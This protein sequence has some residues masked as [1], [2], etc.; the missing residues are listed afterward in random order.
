ML[1]F[2]SYLSVD[3]IW[4]GFVNWLLSVNWSTVCFHTA[5]VLLALTILILIISFIKTHYRNQD[6]YDE[7]KQET[8]TI[9]VYRIDG[10]RNNVRFF[11]LSNIS[12]VK[13]VTMKEFFDGFP[14]RERPRVNEW[15]SEILDGKVTTQYLQTDVIFHHSNKESPSFLKISKADPTKGII[16]LESYLLRY[17]GSENEKGARHYSTES[18]FAQAVKANGVATGI[19]FC[20]SLVPVLAAD[21][22]NDGNHEPIPLDVLKCFQNSVAPFARGKEKLIQASD[23]ELIIAN[24]DMLESA[25]AINF[26]LRVVNTANK[27][28]QSE[29]KRKDRQYEVRAG[30]V[31]NKDLLGDSDAILTEAKRAASNAYDTQNSLSFY[32]KGSEE[33]DQSDIVNYR[34]EVERI[35][36]EKRIVYSYRP[37]Y[38]LGKKSI[39]G[40]IARANPLNTSFASIDELKNYAIRAKDDKNLFAAIAKNLVPRF[41]NERLDKKQLLF[42]TVR[43]S[44]RGFLVPFFSHFKDSA[45][46]NLVF[47]FQ[48]AD[49]QVNLDSAGLERFIET[50][51]EIKEAGFKIA[52]L[53]SGKSLLLDSK[54]Y[55][56]CDAF[57]VDFEDN[58]DDTNMDTKI[59]SELH[60]LVEKLLKYNKPIVANS[61]MSWNAIELVVG[62]G[63]VYISSDVFAPYDTMFRPLN[64]KSEE[65]LVSM[66]KGSS[67]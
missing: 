17:D 11:N 26:A 30:V 47:L 24:F 28:L 37:V 22:F 57:F 13:N 29:K 61:L 10:P 35:I 52:I 33:F 1:I 48:E 44:E 51:T 2:N 25:Q 14:E 31:S 43:M 59:R 32:K 4:D 38:S 23:S 46:A 39:V 8:S 5:F 27:K 67:K 49:I 65:R 19:T 6:Y 64:E 42:Y 40:Y 63:I 56:F 50:L 18:D 45:V 7:I 34:S 62:S 15:I 60:A 53:L 20:F 36:Y 41:V 16:H 3:E 66:K 54:I 12:K 55:S 58:Q 21:S 9:R